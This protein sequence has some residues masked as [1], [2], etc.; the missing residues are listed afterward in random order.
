MAKQGRKAMLSTADVGKLEAKLETMV[1]AADKKY[2][3]TLSMLRAACRVKASEKVI[4]RALHKRGVYFRRFRQ[5]PILSNEDKVARLAFAKKYAKKTA[6]WWRSQVHM[7]IDVKHFPVYLNGKA[8]AHSAQ[9]GARGAF[10]RK[11]QGLE[12]PYIT[13]SKTLKYN[14]GARGVKVLAGVGAGKV[15]AWHYIDNRKWSG[16]VAAEVYKGAIATALRRAHPG[17]RKWSILED[18][19]PS[20]F[21]SRRGQEAKQEVGI[22]PFA[23]PRRSPDL[24]MCDYSLWAE[25][26]RR[27]RKQEKSWPA[28]RKETRKQYLARLRR[29]AKRLPA[30]FLN[31]CVGDMKRRCEKLLAAKGGHFE[32]G[33][34]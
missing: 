4:Q 12:E 15:L 31:K 28:G 3:V 32:E 7:H 17:K 25:I 9:E 27:M 30:A 8:R 16:A 26:S 20:G 14:T 11:G 22:E 2:E 29:T 6:A 21:K 13:H 23:I 24:N 5:K 10:R 1:K 19:D 33:G 34:K 18:N